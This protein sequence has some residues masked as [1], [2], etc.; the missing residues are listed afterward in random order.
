MFFIRHVFEIFSHFYYG[1]KG[2]GTI[3]G[4]LEVLPSH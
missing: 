2:L 3:Y 1:K 4:S